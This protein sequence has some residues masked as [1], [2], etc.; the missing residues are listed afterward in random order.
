MDE[1]APSVIIRYSNQAG[2]LVLIRERLAEPNQSRRLYE[3]ECTGCLDGNGAPDTALWTTRKWAAEH[4][5]TCWALPQPDDAA[6]A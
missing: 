1:Q 4:S 6:K 5:A 3:A 2:A